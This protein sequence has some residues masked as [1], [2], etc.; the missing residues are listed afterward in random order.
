MKYKKGI[1][2]LV[3]MITVSALLLISFVVTN[4]ATKQL[5]LGYSN[6]ESQY[7]YYNSNSGVECALYW[8]LQKN[9]DPSPFDPYITF[10][11]NISCN[12][13]TVTF[14]SPPP[15]IS[16]YS[17]TTFQ[18]DL[19]KGCVILDVVKKVGLSTTTKIES[20][21]YNTCT[22]GALRRFERGIKIVY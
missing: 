18:V 11:T 6:Q 2:L 14:N 1:A 8:D 15:I 19:P 21:G 9:G 20:R 4:I 22:A 16:G 13:H 7:A 17:T 12:S 5:I 10:P 3:T